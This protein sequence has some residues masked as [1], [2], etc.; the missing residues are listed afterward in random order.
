MLLIL[1]KMHDKIKES[2]VKGFSE[3]VETA[4]A[5]G[6]LK[7]DPK[8]FFV[9]TIDP[10]NNKIVVEHYDYRRRIKKKI[11]GD[12]AEALY[13]TIVE[14]GLVSQLDHAAYLGYELGKAETALNKGLNYT[15]D[16]KLE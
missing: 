16:K 3:E 7:L 4:E 2:L 14:K 1:N 6:T 8:G 11:S 5:K 15:Q 10:K 12:S 9:I 13:K